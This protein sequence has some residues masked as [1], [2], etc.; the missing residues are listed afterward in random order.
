MAAEH[1]LKLLDSY[2]FETTIFSNKTPSM[3]HQKVDQGSQNKVVEVLPLETKLLLVPTLEIRSYSDQSLG[4]TPNIFSDSPS[5]NSVLT[6]QK[7]RSIPSETEIREFSMVSNRN[8]DKED[9][10][11]TE[12]KLSNSYIRKSRRR[13]LRKEKGTMSLSELEFKELKGFMD[14]GF[15]FSKED[16]DSKLVSLIP[17]LQRLGRE[18]EE[19]KIDESVISDKPYLS[20]AWGVLEQIEVRNPLLNWKVPVQGNEIDMKHSLRFWAHTV[21]SSIVR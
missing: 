17:G 3:F 20:E 15:V 16:K 6:L 5:P 13:L 2:W 8:H 11:N 10:N 14:L 1:V 7:L 19:H 4:S 9:I 18:E 12:K 21:A